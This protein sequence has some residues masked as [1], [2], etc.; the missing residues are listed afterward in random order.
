MKN[1]TWHV[2]KCYS[3][4]YI[5]QTSSP[6]CASLSAF[7]FL[8]N[9]YGASLTKNTFGRVDFQKIHFL[10]TLFRLFSIVYSISALIMYPAVDIHHRTI[11]TRIIS[12]T[13]SFSS[14]LK[15]CGKRKLH[16]NIILIIKLFIYGFFVLKTDIH[17]IFIHFA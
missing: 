4:Y 2:W 15:F 13:E 9:I 6:V 7:W 11:P 14:Y 3:R 5:P 1:E 8:S 10:K 12:N 17:D 16:L